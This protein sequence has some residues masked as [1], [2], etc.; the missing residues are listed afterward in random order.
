M[1][2][3]HISNYFLHSSRVQEIREIVTSKR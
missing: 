2:A 3:F 1:S